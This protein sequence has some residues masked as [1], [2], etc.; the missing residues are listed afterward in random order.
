M[1]DSFKAEVLGLEDA[2]G[3][4]K[5]T[6]TMLEGA[7]GTRSTTLEGCHPTIWGSVAELSA[8]AQQHH[9]LL[10]GILVSLGKMK[11]ASTKV[12]FTPT[13]GI[14]MEESTVGGL[15]ADPFFADEGFDS[16]PSASASSQ[17]PTI[18]DG[19]LQHKEGGRPAN[20]GSAAGAGGGGSGGSSGGGGGPG[21]SGSSS[22]GGS[23]EGSGR[24][25]AQDLKFGWDKISNLEERL[26]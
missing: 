20:S 15:A 22:D 14:T 24:F 5:A 6:A 3:G 12:S 17:G 11:D 13:S 16:Q 7:I 4:T 9:G 10:K 18:R 25:A 19:Y 2:V 21:R 23:F 26:D 8:T 1:H